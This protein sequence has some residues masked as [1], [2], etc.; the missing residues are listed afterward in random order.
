MIYECR[1]ALA[2]IKAGLGKVLCKTGDLIDVVCCPT[3][4]APASVSSVTTRT[5]TIDLTRLRLSE[6]SEWESGLTI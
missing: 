3:G 4:A 1:Q 5:P 2:D 6:R